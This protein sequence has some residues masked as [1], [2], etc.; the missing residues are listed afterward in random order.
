[1]TGCVRSGVELGFVKKKKN[2]RKLKNG[3][4]EY[5]GNFVRAEKK[6]REN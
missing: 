4:N 5:F 2:L 6:I 3:K 1:M